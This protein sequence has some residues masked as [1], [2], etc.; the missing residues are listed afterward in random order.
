MQKRIFISVLGSIYDDKCC[1]NEMTFQELCETLKTPQVLKQTEEEYHALPDDEKRQLKFGAC[2]CACV[3]NEQG[4]ETQDRAYILALDV[5]HPNATL[6]DDIKARYP[7]LKVFA[8][9]TFRSREDSPH[10]RIIIPLS[11]PVTKDEYAKLCEAFTEKL[12]CEFDKQCFNFRQKLQFPRV[13][14]G[15]EYHFWEWGHSACAVDSPSVTV[16]GTFAEKSHQHP[17]K[18]CSHLTSSSTKR[19]CRGDKDFGAEDLGAKSTAEALRLQVNKYGEPKNSTANAVTIVLED[20]ELS[21]IMYDSFKQQFIA[22]NPLPWEEKGVAHPR[23]FTEFDRKALIGYISST[24]HIETGNTIDNALARLTFCRSIDPLQEYFKGLTWDGESRVE[25]LLTKYLGCED[26]EYTR[27]VIRTTLIS[28]VKRVFEPGCKI[29]MVLVLIGKQ[30]CGKSTFVSKLARGYFT[31]TIRCPD[32][33]TKTAAEK[34]RGVFIAEISEMAGFSKTEVEMVKSFFSCQNDNYREPYARI[35][36]EH[37]RKSIIIGT[38][39]R[40][41]GLLIDETG[42]RRF[43]PV[44]TGKESEAHPWDMTDEDIDQIWAEAYLMYKNGESHEMPAH[45]VDEVL[46]K[47]NEAVVEDIRMPL[48]SEYLDILLPENWYDLSIEDR[49]DYINHT[50]K[51]LAQPYNGTLRRDFVCAAEIGME[52]FGM[53]KV[54]LSIRFS[55]EIALMLRKLGWTEFPSNNGRRRIPG[56]G[57][58]T[59]FCRPESD[60]CDSGCDIK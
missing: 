9:T 29:D 7:D 28:G 49:R 32:I 16:R 43:L 19:S 35:V 25:G 39:N 53:R 15:I 34:L 54:E 22:T 58:G 47:Q 56:Y 10:Y 31:D 44:F 38:S 18:R 50:G 12:N 33:A 20:P 4:D 3:H 51:Y 55:K 17:R 48:V 5:D 60:R 2:F 46:K 6:L 23:V 36:T 11:R 52:F 24:Y 27:A 37:P 14:K 42:N 57:K 41:S 40:I 1:I 30:G 13:L 8:Y 45:L 26:S 59:T 21:G